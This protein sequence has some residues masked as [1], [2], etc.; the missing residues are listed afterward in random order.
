MSDLPNP[1]QSR[2]ESYLGV[3]VEQEGAIKPER[4]LSRVEQYLEFIIEQGVPSGQAGSKVILSIDPSTYVMTLNLLNKDDE[5]ISTTSVDLPLEEM[6]VSGRYDATTKKLILTLK[7]GEEIEIPVGDIIS[8][9]QSQINAV[10]I[11]RGTGNGNVVA[12]TIDESLSFVDGVLSVSSALIQ[13]LTNAITTEVQARLADS[14]ELRTAISTE[15]ADRA[16]QIID[17]AD[18]I[19]QE[20]ATVESVNTIANNLGTRIGTIEGKEAGWDAKQN[21]IP[22]LETIRSGAAAGATA[23]QD[24]NYIHTDNNYT[25]AEKNKLE[26]IE[27]GAEKNA[28]NTVIDA[29]YVH[30]DNNYSDEDKEALGDKL[31]DAP[32]DDD[33]YGRKNGDWVKVL[34][35]TITIAINAT[36]GA[37]IV[38]QSV[39]VYDYDTGTLLQTLSISGDPVT[40]NADYGRKYQVIPT[41]T[42]PQHYCQDRPIFT[43]YGNH[44]VILLYKSLDTIANVQQLKSAAD[45]GLLQYLP[46]GHQ[47][48][49]N[50]AVYGNLTFDLMDYDATLDEVTLLLHDTLSDQR[51]FDSSEATLQ[52][53]E[54]IPAGPKSFTASGTMYYFTTTV[55]VP[56][57]GQIRATDTT[58]YIYPGPESNVELESGTVSTTEIAGAVNLGTCGIGK[59]NH[60]DRIRYGNNTAG[61]AQLIEWLDSRE[62]ANQWFHAKT[63]F[64]R[65]CGYASAPGF[66]NG[67]SQADWDCIEETDVKYVTQNTYAAPGSLYPKNTQYTLRQKIFLPSRTEIWGDKDFDDGTTQY[68]AYVGTDNSAK[69]KRYNGTARIWWLRSPRPYASHERVVDTDGS[70]N[71]DGAYGTYGVVPAFKIRNSNI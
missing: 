58:F 5:V 22:D 52:A 39:A 70:V 18:T 55:P 1:N 45:L 49:M 35:P 53:E 16:A 21:A 63:I 42:T 3:I 56:V 17:L 47:V 14:Q 59:I 26:G 43:V 40:I 25:T 8:G 50:H 2:T 4:P 46:L 34:K 10:G 68:D 62:G 41:V 32:S 67:I 57:G 6:I 66:A 33:I 48:T 38:N 11:L 20:Y 69:I 51:Q 31:D 15:A 28:D 23:V 12:I 71:G 9:L 36:D 19:A 24:A 29:N 37:A 30:T 65:P 7:N 54:S 13:Q 44:S 61:E 27:A 60:W 64:D